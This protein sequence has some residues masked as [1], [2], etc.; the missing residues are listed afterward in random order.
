MIIDELIKSAILEGNG[1]KKE[2]YRAIKNAL[3]K[4]KTSKNP[5]KGDEI[6]YTVNGITIN[7][8]EYSILNSL[9]KQQEESISIYESNSRNDLAKIERN[10]LKYLKELLPEA[11]S[12]DRIE[13]FVVSEYPNGYSKNQMK[14]VI[15]SVKKIFP[16]ADGKLIF[17]VVKSHIV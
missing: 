7:K 14:S 5:I 10:Q 16:T 17:L 3:L 12:E 2:A 9:I 15:D 13:E 4:N 6:I 1:S 8:V 11:I